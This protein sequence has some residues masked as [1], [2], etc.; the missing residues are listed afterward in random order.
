[1]AGRQQWR[2]HRRPNPANGD[3]LGSVPKMGADETAPLSTPP[4]APCPPGVRSRLKTRQH[5]AQLVQFNDGASGRFTRLMTLEQ[6]KPLAE[7]KGE[8]STPPPLLSG[9]PKKAN[10]FMATPSRSSGR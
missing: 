10:V 5:S 6:G 3:K 2:G 4:T 8:I 7:A 1:M 9:L